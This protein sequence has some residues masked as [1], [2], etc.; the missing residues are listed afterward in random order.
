MISQR[1]AFAMELLSWALNRRIEHDYLDI[2]EESAD[3]TDRLPTEYRADAVTSGRTRFGRRR[4]YLITEVQSEYKVEKV[5]AWMG[6][7][8][9]LMA[10]HKS[11]VHLLVYCLDQ[12][13]A[14]KYREQELI[15]QGSSLT[16]HPIVICPQDLPVLRESADVQRYP[17][18]ATLRAAAPPHDFDTAAAV[19]MSLLG[20]EDRRGHTYYDYLR[21]KLPENLRKRLEDLMIET[22]PRISD[23]FTQSLENAAE[24]KG[25]AEGEAEG[26][27]K[28]LRAV[29]EARGLEITDEQRQ[30]IENCRDTEQLLTWTTRA[31]T[32]A[33]AE[34]IFGER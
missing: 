28:A 19:A 26:E 34:E 8:G 31:A 30:A 6:Y 5:W 22:Q 29:L 15:P 7:T 33:T 13:T 9:T 10:K 4:R 12:P 3:L 24:A 17:E 20:F 16:L 23:R 18:F 32:A 2:R 25:R 21:M 11:V 27:A 1:P 14:R